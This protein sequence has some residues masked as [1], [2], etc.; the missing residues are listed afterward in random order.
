MTGMLT[1]GAVARS[2][3]VG[4][5]TLRYYERRG[6]LS[7]ALRTRAGYRQYRPDEIRR[8]HFI[9]RAQT[10]GFTLD[11]IREL[12]ALRVR[13]GHPCEHVRRATQRTRERV[14]A[15]LADLR[16]MDVVLRKLI[17]SC[18]RRRATEP[19]PI[20]TM[21]TNGAESDTSS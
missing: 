1:I 3:G 6:L 20:L 19:C 15:R 16:R 21:L 13:D 14:S 10:L 11:E 18:D 2:A 12:L 9:R 4:V 17:Q 8:V 7:K 5:Q